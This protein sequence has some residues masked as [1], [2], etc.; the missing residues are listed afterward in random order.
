MGKLHRELIE[1]L[2]EA[3]KMKTVLLVD[4]DNS[5]VL[6]IGT[7]LKSMGYAVVAAKD[8]V[9]A[10]STFRKNKPDVVVL[11]ISMPAGD[12]FGVA[13]RLQSF[14]GFAAA[15]I[16]FITSSEDP[17]IRARAMKHGVAFF[18]KP[19]DAGQLASAIESALSRSDN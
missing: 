7:R 2:T 8:A 4:D 5:V 15:P 14:D 6:T 16:I 9:A 12:G 3:F 10:I 13:D 11:D 19:I 1:D 17:A 18:R